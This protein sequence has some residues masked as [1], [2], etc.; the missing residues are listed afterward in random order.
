[1]KVQVTTTVPPPKKTCEE[2]FQSYIETDLTPP[3]SPVCDNVKA[4][5]TLQLEGLNLLNVLVWEYDDLILEYLDEGYF[6]T[7]YKVRVY[8]QKA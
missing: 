5:R 7:V 2:H 6:G 3:G 8:L 1:M 4:K